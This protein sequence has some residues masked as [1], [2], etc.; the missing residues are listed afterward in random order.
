M[1]HM[2]LGVKPIENGFERVKI[3]PHLMGLSHA[4]GRVPTAFGY[5]DVSWKVSGK[6]FVLDVSS[7]KEVEMEI[8]LPSG[9]TKTVVS[10]NFSITE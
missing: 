8:I 4:K 1:V 9:K 10:K 7:S 3:E 5:I 2:I 6:G